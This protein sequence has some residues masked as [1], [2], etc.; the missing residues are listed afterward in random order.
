MATG[1]A[2]GTTPGRTQLVFPSAHLQ[3]TLK[4][5]MAA[6]LPGLVTWWPRSLLDGGKSHL[7]KQ[8]DS[9]NDHFIERHGSLLA[10]GAK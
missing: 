4:L 6:G 1:A 5:K 7:K 10:A 2:P 8:D 3:F 9:S